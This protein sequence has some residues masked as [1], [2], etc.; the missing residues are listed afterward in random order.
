LSQRLNNNSRK[1][2]TKTNTQ[3]TIN[4]VGKH[5]YEVDSGREECEKNDWYFL[6]LVVG[7]EEILR[8]LVIE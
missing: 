4:T 2:N 7:C 1:A 3:K 6:V 8:G 5:N